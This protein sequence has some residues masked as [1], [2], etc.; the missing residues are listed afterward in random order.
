MVVTVH[1]HQQ[2]PRGKICRRQRIR[3]KKKNENGEG[4]SQCVRMS[5]PF[6]KQI[7]NC[8]GLL[9]AAVFLAKCHER[10]SAAEQRRKQKSGRNPYKSLC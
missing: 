1:F 9:L 10:A 2:R 5:Y 7:E 3:Q 4:I 8:G 6:L